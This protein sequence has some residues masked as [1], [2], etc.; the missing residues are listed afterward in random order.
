MTSNKTVA[1]KINLSCFVFDGSE[2]ASSFNV[3][4]HMGLHGKKGRW[5][6]GGRGGGLASVSVVRHRYD[7][8]LQKIIDSQQNSC[9]K[10][11]NKQ[12]T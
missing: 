9:K 4:R 5:G 1:K 6:G 12:Q 3:I 7:S 10:Q 11:A 8:V 2:R